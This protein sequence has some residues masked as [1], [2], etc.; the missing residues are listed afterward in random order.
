MQLVD[1]AAAALAGDDEAAV[2]DPRAGIDQAVDVL[3]DGQAATA[4]AAL[5]RLGAVLV[6]EELA[7]IEQR[8]ELRPDVVEVNLGR[9]GLDGADLGGFEEGERVAFVDDGAR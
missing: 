3:A 8:L 6:E 1:G 9:G 5:D 4:V 2:L 7:A